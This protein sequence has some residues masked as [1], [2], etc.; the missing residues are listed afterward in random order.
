[1]SAMRDSEPRTAAS[2]DDALDA[3]SRTV[4]AVAERVQPSVASLRHA[5]GSGSAVALTGDGLLVTSAHVIGRGRIGT[6]V[7]DNGAELP[8]ELVGSDRLSDLAVV[9]VPESNLPVAELGDAGAFARRSARRRRR[10]PPRLRR[11]GVGRRGV[12]TGTLAAA[13]WTVTASGWS[14][15]SSRPTPHS[16]PGTAGVRS[17][18]VTRGWSG[19]QHHGRRPRGRAGPRP[20]RAPRR[21]RPW[22]SS[23]RSSPT[24][25]IDRAELGLSGGSRA[26]PPPR[27][28][29]VGAPPRCRGH[30]RR[31]RRDHGA[32]GLSPRGHRRRPRRPTCRG[33][34]RHATPAD[35]RPRRAHDRGRRLVRGGEVLGVAVVPRAL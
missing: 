22:P 6:A 18:P 11:L 8:Y 14:R 35:G 23:G 28:R 10:Q 24:G 12:G 26:L 32:G 3:Y 25:G 9:H 17:R 7:F 33:G 34:Q 2:D 27:R 20:G 5:A 4:V 1:M 16:T 15:A 13:R 30:E 31:G 29:P 19:H 21:R